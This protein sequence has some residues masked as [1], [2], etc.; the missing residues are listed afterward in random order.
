MK[1][2]SMNIKTCM[3]NIIN[4]GLAIM[5]CVGLFSNPSI[6]AERT[7]V[8]FTTSE[9]VID[10]ELFNDK[11]PG[12]VQNFVEYVEN[13]FYDGLIF[14]RVIP[15]FVI[16]GGGMEPGMKQ[17]ETRDPIENEADNGEKNLVGT[18][19]MARTNNPHSASS[20]FFINLADNAFLDHT[21]KNAQGWGY[22]VFGKVSEGMEIVEKIAATT[23]TTVGPYQDVPEN[24]IVITKAEVLTQ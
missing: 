10:I 6:G 11:A 9:G 23:T 15:G 16:Q 4:T 21:A 24:D 1:L 19:S 8:R 7:M 13:G 22:A 18:L 14:H 17:R 20:Q 5:L 12:T 2:K 3:R